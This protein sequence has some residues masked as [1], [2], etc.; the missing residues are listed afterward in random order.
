MAADCHGNN[1]CAAGQ[2]PSPVDNACFAVGPPECATLIG[3]DPAAC[4]PRYCTDL[5]PTGLPV[6][7]TCTAQELAAGSG[8]LAGEFAESA[9]GCRPAGQS[10]WVARAGMAD[11]APT[12]PSQIPQ[13][14]P[15]PPTDATDFCRD[16]P[17]AGE[18]LCRADELP[19]QASPAG[20]GCLRAGVP[21]LCPPGFVVSGPAQAGH[22]PGCAPDPADCGAGI[23]GEVPPGQGAIFVLQGAPPNGNGSQSQPFASVFEALPSLTPGATLVLGA[24]EYPMPAVLL[25]AELTIAGRCA[26]LVTLVPPVN[27]YGIEVKGPNGL[28]SL[29]NV[30]IAGAGIAVTVQGQSVAHLDKVLVDGYSQIGL[31]VLDAGSRLTATRSVVASPAA[32]AFPGVGV[33]VGDGGQLQMHQCRVT[34][35]FAA[36]IYSF[37]AASGIEIADTVVDGT[38]LDPATKKVAAGILVEGGAA[39]LLRLALFNHAHAGLMVK[40]Q[41]TVVA[42]QRI[43]IGNTFGSSATSPAEGLAIGNGAKVTLRASRITQSRRSAILVGEAGLPTVDNS[44]CQLTAQGLLIDGRVLPAGDHPGPGILVN[45]DSRF[46]GSDVRVT[47]VHGNGVWASGAA[48]TLHLTRALVDH[49]TADPPT[50]PDVGCG[51]QLRQGSAGTLALVRVTQTDDCGIGAE[52]STTVLTGAD[53]YVDGLATRDGIVGSGRGVEIHDY[54]TA[55]LTGVTVR[56]VKGVGVAVLTHAQADVQQFAVLGSGRQAPEASGLGIASYD[57]AYLRLQHGVVAD[58]E[59]LNLLADLSATAELADVALIASAASQGATDIGAL[60][61][62]GGQLA[63]T[64]VRIANPGAVAML[65]A[66]E[67]SRGALAGASATFAQFA[68][69]P[70]AAGLA[71]GD[72]SQ[73]RLVSVRIA[74]AA[75]LGIGVFFNAGLIAANSVVA[76]VQPRTVVNHR[77]SDRLMDVADAVLGMTATTLTLDHCV[78]AAPQRAGAALVASP[79]VK[80]ADCLVTQG[81]F[82]VVQSGPPSKVALTRSVVTGNTQDLASDQG[83]AVPPAPKTVDISL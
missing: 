23:F 17:Q 58:T 56:Q 50:A 55:A 39:S 61:Q 81:Y 83:L 73:G 25:K 31:R 12:I 33:D 53:L 15:L 37:G 24:G 59:G 21:W 65:V 70:G 71:F 1:C 19:C 30:R 40:G 43:V 48:S 16:S 10:A 20:K 79:A 80:L 66:G 7:R 14:L 76:H 74:G 34:G 47:G 13:D 52:N 51:V 38:G 18:R 67:A 44:G 68:T 62:R 57:A 75:G 3:A 2:L 64:G 41:G 72:G 5:S 42:A 54:A 29:R 4:V 49:V 26:K 60:V 69:K 82:G 9:G 36:G 78:L 32:T 46:E 6:G 8:C 63:A 11:S 77:A 45:A 28:L 27:S 22:W 35:A